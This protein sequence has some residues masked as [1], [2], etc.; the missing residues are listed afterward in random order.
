MLTLA[1]DTSSKTVAVALLQDDV[2]LYDAIINVD[3]N[4]SEILLSAIDQA[5]LQTRINISGID[6]IA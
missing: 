5:C 2:I 1:F 4:H 3:L 6:L